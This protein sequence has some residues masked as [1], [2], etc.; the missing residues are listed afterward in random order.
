M[1]FVLAMVEHQYLDLNYQTVEQ[2]SEHVVVVKPELELGIELVV[3]VGMK[4][5]RHNLV[6][7][8]S[9]VVYDDIVFEV[10]LVVECKE[11]FV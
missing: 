7:Y 2:Q 8:R 4:F 9:V 10:G 5:D 11:V 1:Q 6:D 3:K